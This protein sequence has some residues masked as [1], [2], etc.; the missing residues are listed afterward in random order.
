MARVA[1]IPRTDDNGKAMFTVEIRAIV[2]RCA[3]R[4]IEKKSR[5]LAGT[6]QR[7]VAISR[8]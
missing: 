4:A 8:R 2:A 1:H 7:G 3:A 5:E 6:D